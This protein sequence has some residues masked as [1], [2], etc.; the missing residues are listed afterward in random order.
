MVKLNL[1]KKD[2]LS[3]MPVL[4]FYFSSM[5][6]VLLLSWFHQQIPDDRVLSGKESFYLA[7]LLAILAFSNE[8][9]EKGMSLLSVVPVRRVTVFCSKLVV[10]GV[11]ILLV[12]IFNSI[13]LCMYGINQSPLSTQEL[14][15]QIFNYGIRSLELGL[16]GFSLGACFYRSGR[17]I[18]IW[19]LI[20]YMILAI[21]VAAHV[22]YAHY[23][24]ITYLADPAFYWG[25]SW[26][27]TAQKTLLWFVTLPLL[28]AGIIRLSMR[29]FDAIDR[30][31][32][33]V[34]SCFHQ[35]CRLTSSIS[36]I[37]LISF[38]IFLSLPSDEL[39]NG[40]AASGDHSLESGIFKF[41]WSG[42]ETRPMSRL[43]QES[44]EI[45]KH[46]KMTLGITKEPETA[47]ITVEFSDQP[48][49]HG[50][51]GS[52]HWNK[53]ML[54]YPL[55]GY[56]QLRIVF[57]HELTHILAGRLSDGE[58]SDPKLKVVNEGLATWVSET[59]YGKSPDSNP[60]LLETEK[61]SHSLLWDYDE[62]KKVFGS[63]AE[64]EAGRIAID[65][66]VKSYGERSIKCFLQNLARLKSPGWKNPTANRDGVFRACNIDRLVI[67]SRVAL[68]ILMIKA[69][70]VFVRSFLPP[71]HVQMERSEEG[72]SFRIAREGRLDLEM[73]AQF[74]RAPDAPANE[75]L[76]LLCRHSAETSCFIPYNALPPNEF[77][78]K[79][80]WGISKRHG[81]YER[82]VWGS[83]IRYP[84]GW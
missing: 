68:E 8:V 34:P 58:F 24:F 57:A 46:V 73:I 78:V 4:I 82:E 62:L 7:M 6:A 19:L 45:L 53:I 81:G 65:Q 67:E 52:A 11:I 66:I 27:S 20:T 75:Y 44:E 38:S 25:K 70:G 1:V 54:S 15:P 50:N 84:N 55:K 64:Y 14:V 22:P 32:R 13:L 35:L 69:Q 2:L 41:S 42:D 29:G 79:A 76:R 30:R 48:D 40:T 9:P 80:G 31:S 51:E 43:F 12:V 77:E 49:F 72:I 36:F 28:M 17:Y 83:W 56:T 16:F 59:L 60:D 21:L 47:P 37:I 26:N 18:A 61:F 33:D 23:L 39:A 63:G 3:L 71:L 5:I 10:V 74:R